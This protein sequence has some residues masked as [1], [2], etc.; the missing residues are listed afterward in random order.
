MPQ[1]KHKKKQYSANGVVAQGVQWK[2]LV[3]CYVIED[4]RLRAMA[5][6]IYVAKFIVHP[7]PC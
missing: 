2:V 1:R 3:L 6:V 4:S 7:P 5:D